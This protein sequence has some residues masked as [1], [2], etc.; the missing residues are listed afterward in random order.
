MIRDNVELQGN[1]RADG[2][3][4]PHSLQKLIPQLRKAKICSTDVNAAWKEYTKNKSRKR[5]EA[6]P[7]VKKQ[8]RA[9][10]RRARQ[11]GKAKMQ[12]SLLSSKEGVCM[13]L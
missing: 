9:R 4:W 7:S 10:S 5:L 11:A 2:R 6:H 12:I 3:E 1:M 13:R 8:D